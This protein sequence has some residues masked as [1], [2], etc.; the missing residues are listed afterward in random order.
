[1]LP[2]CLAGTFLALLLADDL[3]D[4]LLA[5]AGGFANHG[6]CQACL[7]R[8]DDRASQLRACPLRRRRPLPHLLA[9]VHQPVVSV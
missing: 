3:M 7:T 6:Q 8:G 1:M 5:E 4:A 2:R 9:L